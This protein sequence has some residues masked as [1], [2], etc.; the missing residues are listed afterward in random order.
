MMC[1]LRA[2]RERWL[3]RADVEASV[4][5]RRI[6]PDNFSAK[7]PGDGEGERGFAGCGRANDNDEGRVRGCGAHR[8]RI[9]HPRT[10]RITS[11]TA[12]RRMLPITCWRVGFTAGSESPEANCK[13]KSLAIRYTGP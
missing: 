13:G 4:Q 1:N 12:A 3:R 6:A 2:F 8:N 11:T 5:L 10:R 9:C 7:L